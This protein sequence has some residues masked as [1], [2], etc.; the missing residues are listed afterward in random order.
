MPAR[1]APTAAT[2]T[3]TM[4]VPKSGCSKINPIGTPVRAPTL[5]KSPKDRRSVRT[6]VKKR[7]STTI[8]INFANSDTWKN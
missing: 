7:A 1:Y 6:S 5:I 4:A 3:S 8:I 2:G